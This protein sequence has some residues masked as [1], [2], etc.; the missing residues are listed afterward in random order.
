MTT[1]QVEEDQ[2][3]TAGN[4]NDGATTTTPSSSSGGGS[5]GAGMPLSSKHSS[6]HPLDLSRH[7][8]QHDPGNSK[9]NNNDDHDDDQEQFDD[10]FALGDDNDVVDAEQHANDK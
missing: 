7:V 4:N 1:K 8:S 6:E 9:N 10:S 5:G 3:V 2:E